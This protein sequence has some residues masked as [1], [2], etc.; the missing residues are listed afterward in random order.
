MKTIIAGSRDFYIDENALTRYIKNVPWN[1]TEVVSGGCRG[2]DQS[3]ESWALANGIDY[4]VFLAE[5]V[6]LGKS[7]GPIRNQKMA[8]YADALIAFPGQGRGTRDMI[9][10]MHKLNKPVWVFEM[11]NG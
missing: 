2:I 9:E 6:Q 7:A 10:R 1:I 8:E 3:G 11:P 4:K 5:W